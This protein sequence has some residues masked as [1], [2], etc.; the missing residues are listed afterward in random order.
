[1]KRLL[2]ILILI[3]I[4]AGGWYA[5]KLYTG[6]VPSLTEKK[7]DINISAAD[8]V[9][10]FEKDTASA[11]KTYLGK[12]LAVN[13]NVRSVEKESASIVLGNA[14]SQSSV[15]CSMD[16]AFVT[17]L[18]TITEG[19]TITV[20]GACTGFNADETGLGLGSDVVLNRCV[21]E[22]TNH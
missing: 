4:L 15:R 1:M 19:S 22:T 14:G 18:S 8:L 11:N 16:T 21:L 9:A 10:A 6:K 5:Y 12:I 2:L 20:K 13:G 7:A 3:V 17:K